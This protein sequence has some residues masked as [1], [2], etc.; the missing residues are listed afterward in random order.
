MRIKQSLKLLLG[1]L[2]LAA[3]VSTS[4]TAAESFPSR[5]L[6]IVVGASPGGLIDIT[7]RVVAERMGKVL[8]QNVI[9][10]NRPGASTAIGSRTV[11]SA[12]PDGYTL[13]SATSSVATLPFVKI[14]PGYDLIKDFTGIGPISRAP[15][16]MLVRPGASMDTLKD[17]I[18]LAKAKPGKLTYASSG[19]GGSIHLGTASFAQHAGLD[20]MHIPYKSNPEA[21]PDV[22][23]GRVDTIFE[24][25]GS[26]LPL[27]QDKRLQAI[28]VSSSARIK[29]LPNVPTLAEAGAP[30]FSYYIWLG[31][32][33]PAGTPQDIVDSLSRAL[34]ETI[35]TPELQERF[36]R[37]GSEPML[38]ST[39]EFKQFI[40]DETTGF[41]KL[42]GDLHIPKQ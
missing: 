21:W 31:L 40:K 39:G 34:Q 26:A 23:D 5:T 15:L 3:V 25:Y 10:E 27:I 8:G 2:S 1:G 22:T 17:F 37:E 6:R 36:A 20:L 11:K 12:K 4:A 41:S 18:S 7:T 24:P 33:A 35:K 13:L 16:L 9:V 38:M 42:I 30:G 32:F 14:N 19:L 29:M 28:G